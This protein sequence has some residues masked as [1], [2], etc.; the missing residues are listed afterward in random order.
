MPDFFFWGGGCRARSTYRAGGG[1][2][3]GPHSLIT[4]RVRVETTK[5]AYDRIAPPRAG[6]YYT[7]D[8]NSSEQ[9]VCIMQL[10]TFV[11]KGLS[12]NYTCEY[13]A[14]LSIV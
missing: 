4:G 11:F 13:V 12:E 8:G 14:I 7:L 2:Q 1:S 3:I 9:S 5:S 10:T 6:L